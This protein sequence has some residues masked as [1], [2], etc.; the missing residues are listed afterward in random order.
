MLRN[1][2]YAHTDG[3]RTT[4]PVPKEEPVMPTD[5][6]PEFY[7]CV[8]KFIHLANTLMKIMAYSA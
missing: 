4:I 8:D 7:D 1:E 2:Y 5:V 6:P 3:R